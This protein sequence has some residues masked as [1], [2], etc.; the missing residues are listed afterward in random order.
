MVHTNASNNGTIGLIGYL[1]YTASHT[2]IP[3]RVAGKGCS[4]PINVRSNP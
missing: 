1:Q 3:H 4:E 2:I